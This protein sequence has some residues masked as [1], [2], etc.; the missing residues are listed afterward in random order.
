MLVY[1][2]FIILFETLA[3]H[4]FK[5]CHSE[6]DIYKYL[7]GVLFYGFVWYFLIRAYEH[8]TMGMINVLWSS[9]SVLTVMTLS[10]FYWG[11]NVTYNDIIGSVFVIVGL[12]FI[13]I[14]DRSDDSNKITE[15]IR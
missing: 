9:M 2:A 13:M 1:V 7:L 5:L 8:R 11:E 10:Y 12:L 15:Q 4:S 14:D 3:Q 6:A